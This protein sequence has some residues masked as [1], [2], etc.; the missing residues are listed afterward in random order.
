MDA[1]K[2]HKT[3]NMPC[4]ASIEY[5]YNGISCRTMISTGASIAL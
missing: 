5:N 3:H 4:T 2:E 1:A